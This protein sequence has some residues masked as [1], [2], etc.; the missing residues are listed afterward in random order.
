MIDGTSTSIG[1]DVIT[2]IDGTVIRT[3]YDLMYYMERNNRPGDVVELTII[4]GGST[5]QVDVTLGTRPAPV[6]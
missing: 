3:F 1:G 2:A 5:I 6:A 4:R